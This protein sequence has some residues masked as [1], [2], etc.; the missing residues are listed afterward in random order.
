MKRQLG[1]WM[2]AVAL[3]AFGMSCG[4]G[5]AGGGTSDTELDGDGADANQTDG[6]TV[7]G[8]V[9]ET[10]QT[11]GDTELN[12]DTE[13]DNDTEPASMLTW[14][15]PATGLTWQNP[16][17]EFMMEWQEAKDYCTGLALE[18]DG[19][20]LPTISELRS[21]IRGCSATESG[22]SC[23]VND[24][25]LSRSTCWGDS[26]LGCSENAGPGFEG[27]YWPS[28]L[29]GPKS[30]YW[31]SSPCEDNEAIAWYVDFYTGLLNYLYLSNS[32]Y[33]RCVR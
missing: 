1:I 14:T 21:L 8:D 7:D 33:V 32:S 13:V 30:Y 31:S 10:G 11:D 23:G 20:R 19:W 3:V 25:C 9:A 22:G 2:L 5:D 16:P 27:R 18:G 17:S 6:D 15:D 26:C 29:Q 12:G 28:E 24:D 4:S